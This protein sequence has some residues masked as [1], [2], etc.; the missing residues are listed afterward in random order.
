[1]ISSIFG[2]KPDAKEVLKE[3]TRNLKRNEREI[4]REK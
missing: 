2:K 1:M 4:E 3:E